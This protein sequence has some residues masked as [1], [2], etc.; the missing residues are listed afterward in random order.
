MDKHGNVRVLG[1]E[2]VGGFA[3]ECKSSEVLYQFPSVN[4]MAGLETALLDLASRLDSIVLL[5]GPQGPAGDDSAPGPAGADGG[6]VPGSSM[7]F[8]EG[9]PFTVWLGQVCGLRLGTV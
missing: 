8:A 6:P 7:P 1:E 5:P 9:G 2:L 4:G 3:T